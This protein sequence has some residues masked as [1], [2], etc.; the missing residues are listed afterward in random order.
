MVRTIFVTLI[1]L[2]FITHK[3]EAT[4]SAFLLSK[5]YNYPRVSLFQQD[6]D[7]KSVKNELLKKKV[8]LI[9]RF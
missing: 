4:V 8:T 6:D 2:F 3:A 7:Q 9:L 5:S 1:V